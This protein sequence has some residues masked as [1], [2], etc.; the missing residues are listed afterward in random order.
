MRWA[1]SL[2]HENIVK[3]IWH[4]QYAAGYE[5][6]S[7]CQTLS[8]IIFINITSSKFV[9]LSWKLKISVSENL[10]QVKPYVTMIDKIK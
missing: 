1:S 3:I 10:L 7:Y 5:T 8:N 9:N 4:L 2:S 6:N